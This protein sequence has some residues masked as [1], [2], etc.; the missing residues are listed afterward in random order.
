MEAAGYV[1]TPSYS[2]A[3]NLAFTGSTGPHPINQTRA[4]QHHEA[5]F[6]DGDVG[7]RGH[8]RNI[9]ISSVKEIGIGMA[10]K[11]NYD[12]PP[13]GGTQFNAV[14]STYNFAF[15]NEP[16]SNRPFF[17][18]VVYSDATTNNNFYDVGEGLAGVTVT[19]VG[20]PINY[21]TTTF[22][23]GGYSLPVPAGTYAVTFSGGPLAAPITYSNVT[24]R[25]DKQK[26]RR[27]RA[28]RGLEYRRHGRL[29][30][31]D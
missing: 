25:H 31:S 12:P 19:A 28:L 8:R 11:A 7:G 22:A 3:E 29:G 24:D 10:A 23:S 6:I 20:A 5:L 4:N 18:G 2:L 13:A 14:I 26:A 16:P 9:L 1:F 30:H 17:T 15:S 21:S 27:W